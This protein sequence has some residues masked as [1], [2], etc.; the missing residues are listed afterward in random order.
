MSIVGYFC[1][2]MA[3]EISP[4]IMFCEIGKK[5][6]MCEC[7]WVQIDL[8]GC[9]RVNDHGEKQKQG[10]NKRNWVRS[11]YFSIHAHREKIRKSVV[12][13][14]GM[15]EDYLEKFRA[16]KRCAMRYACL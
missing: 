5:N 3:G 8:D 2:D 6:G 12:M 9:N 14:M 16:R 7:T 10:K 11:A 4:D 1:D 15:R 13:V